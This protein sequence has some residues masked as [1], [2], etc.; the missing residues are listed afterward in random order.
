MKKQLLVGAL[1]FAF[2]LLILQGMAVAQA[3][4]PEQEIVL[5]GPETGLGQFYT[6]LVDHKRQD[7]NRVFSVVDQ[8]DGAP[9]IRVSGED[10]GG[11][12]TREAYQDYRLIVEMRWGDVTW[13]NRRDLARDSGILLHCRG[14]DGNTREDFNGPWMTSVETQIIEGGIGDFILVS[15]YEESG[16]R[17]GPEGRARAA[18]DRDG[19]WFYDPWSE[20]RPFPP[21]RINWWGRDPD[22]DGSL[23]F[24]GKKDVESPLGEWTRIEVVCDGSDIT[25]IVNGHVVNRLHDSTY[26]AGKIMIQSEGAEIYF[27]KIALLPLEE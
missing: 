21:G 12:V 24:R 22:W 5:F 27:R 25:N 6:W 11:F 3:I 20:L 4:E 26:T 9:A 15:G 13:G 23:G 16:E 1:S 2:C 10:W 8:V 19:E 17:I 18:Q 7:P 14:A